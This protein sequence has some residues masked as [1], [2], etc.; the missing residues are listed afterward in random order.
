MD[1]LERNDG[2]C[3]HVLRVA[4]PLILAQTSMTIMSFVDRLFLADYSLDAMAGAMFASLAGWTTTCLFV[5][6]A[7]YT[8][9]FV[10]Q[11]Y[12]A[13]R[14]DRVSPAV[15]HG[16][17]LAAGAGVLLF[18]MSF[19]AGP[20]MRL[21]GH[22]P[23]VQ[24][25]EIAYFR[26]FM[27]G[28]GFMTLSSALASFYGGLAKTYYN[29]L[30]HIP[31]HCLNV[32][33]NYCLIFG[34]FGFPRW[35]TKGAATAT[36][37]SAAFT[38]LLIAAVMRWG[39]LGRSYGVLRAPRFER[40]LFVR[41]LKYGLPNGLQWTVDMVGWTLFVALV[42]R[43]G[44]VEQQAVSIA[45]SISFMAFL[46]MMGFGVATSILVGQFVGAG[47]ISLAEK[48]TSSALK[49]TLAY[50]VLIGAV[51]VF[52]PRLLVGLHAP[53]NTPE[54][55][56]QVYRLA[57]VFLRFVALYSLFD[58]VNIV[59]SGALKGA[60]D[61]RFVMFMIAVFSATCL[62][63]PIYTAVKFFDAG[64]YTA[65]IIVT[66]YITVVALGFI[67]RYRAGRWKS[68]CVIERDS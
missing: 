16:V 23:Q 65:G 1:A 41:L 51:F 66:F 12:G 52:M 45:F 26:V 46:P 44:Q 60:G 68:M 55:W 57:V 11:Y 19:L 47:R 27:A 36:V 39:K 33:L 17:Y 25:E 63:A 54:N 67:L 62:V 49:M 20:L 43:I 22:V 56:G 5:G 32:F 58:A 2:G 40:E 4:L 6:T 9:T 15:W 14:R 42:C 8:G 48:S 24:K 64:I 50:M 13:G 34:H 31:G 37:I 61:T 29:M 7:S 3:R 18:G 59:Y 21:A 35:G 53:E 28:A 30:L 38:C 10:A